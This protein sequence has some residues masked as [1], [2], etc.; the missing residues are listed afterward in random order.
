ML[1]LIRL[2][3]VLFAPIIRAKVFVIALIIIIVVLVVVLA[4]LAAT[5]SILSHRPR[6]WPSSLERR[7][8]P[9]RRRL[10][11]VLYHHW[12]NLGADLIK[13]G[14]QLRRVHMLHVLHMSQ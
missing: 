4:F 9:C 12:V 11:D 6:A 10:Q 3:L 8:A 1:S 5:L 13:Q 7:H 14:A 2:R